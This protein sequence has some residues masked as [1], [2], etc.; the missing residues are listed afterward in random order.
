MRDVSII[1]PVLKAEPFIGRT[2]DAVKKYFNGTG[3]RYEVIVVGDSSKCGSLKIAA[4]H[5]GIFDLRIIDQVNRGKGYAVKT[6]MLQAK[7]TVRLFMDAD[8]S[9]EIDNLDDFLFYLT[10]GYDVVI[11]SIRAR[12]ADVRDL[13]RKY[14]RLMAYLGNF[15]IRAFVV[16]GI[17][18][19]QRGF[20]LFSAKAADKI[21]SRQT[22]ERFAFDIELLAIARANGL[23]VKE[24]PVKWTNPS[25]P[26]VSWRTNFSVLRDLFKIKLN[27]FLG[28]YR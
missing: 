21:F 11:A 5:K 2:L 23:R 8:S 22:I 28:K 26:N 17:K 13:N 20:K 1:I 16:P 10:G 19:T 12:G 6:G 4:G 18:D 27:I 15:L 25:S 9:V 3:A 7:G 14:R 24:L